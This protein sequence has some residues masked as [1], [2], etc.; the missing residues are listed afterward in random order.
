MVRAKGD[1]PFFNQQRQPTANKLVLPIAMNVNKLA[2]PLSGSNFETQ[3][4]FMDSNKSQ[5][6][7]V[8]W[9]NLV[10]LRPSALTTT[11]Q[12]VEHAQGHELPVLIL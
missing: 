3:N 1:N 10:C 2:K 9:L 6:E 4:L 8:S 12:Q 5:M 7:N 11:P